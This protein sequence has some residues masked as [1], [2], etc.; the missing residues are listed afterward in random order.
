MNVLVIATDAFGGHGGIA[1]YVRNVLKALC[2]HPSRPSV[3]AIPRVAP[4]RSEPLPAG[5][6]WDTSALNGKASYV[7]SVARAA[8]RPWD[9]VICTHIHLLPL[10]YA[11]KQIRRAPLAL[12]VY[13][14]EVY[15]PTNKPLA[16]RLVSELDAYVSI[17]TMT[18]RRFRSWAKVDRV[19]SFQLE[20]AIDLGRYGVGP[21]NPE[22]VARYGLQ[23]KKVILAMGRVQETYKGFDEVIEVLPRLALEVPEVVFVVAGTGPD[24]PRLEAKARALGVA[25]RVVFT[26]FVS[27]EAKADHYRLADVYAMPGSGPLFDRYPLRFVFLEA[28]ACGIPV[29]GPVPEDEEEAR[30]DGALLTR[31]VDP[32][33]PNDI[34]RGILGALREGKREIPKGL[35]R[36]S[37]AV[38]E[39]RMHAIVDDLLTKARG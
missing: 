6:T 23:G 9:L 12:F 38:F 17:R 15:R 16:N 21:K 18:T 10:A 25:D 14:S 3:L 28:M 37:Y 31:L 39:R 30:V 33:N 7:A 19:R 36:Y 4:L 32:S 29:V 26:G 27:D 2:V 22:L 11:V 24:L 13:G 8:L 35:E 1:L 20:N 5:L 34:V